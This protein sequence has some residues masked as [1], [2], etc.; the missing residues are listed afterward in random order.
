MKRLIT[1]AVAAIAFA[2][3]SSEPSLQKYFVESQDKKDFVSVDIGTSVLQLKEDAL[4]ADQRAALK[5]FEKV[6]LL[7]FQ[8]NDSNQTEYKAESEK[9]KKMLKNE[10]YQELMHFGSGKDGGSISYVGADDDIEEFV[11]FANRKENGFAVVRIL[12]NGMSPNSIMQMLPVLQSSNLNMEQLKPL[13]QLMQPQ[14]NVK[15]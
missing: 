4:T 10:K 6:N 2:A 9:V 8:S 12:G 7:V 11:I 1:L 14:G 15:P 3:C 13:Q 5:T